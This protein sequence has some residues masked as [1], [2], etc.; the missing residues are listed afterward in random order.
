M[1]IQISL[2]LWRTDFD[3]VQTHKNLKSS[4]THRAYKKIKIIKYVHKY[5]NLWD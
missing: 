2:F 1:I 3:C 5:I 4:T